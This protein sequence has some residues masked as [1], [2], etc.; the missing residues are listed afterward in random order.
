MEGPDQT[1]GFQAN[2][3]ACDGWRGLYYMLSTLPLDDP[4]FRRADE[5]VDRLRATGW[6]T[7][8]LAIER[9]WKR[10][11]WA[12]DQCCGRVLEIGAGM[13]NVTRWIA[14]NPEVREVVALDITEE[15]IRAL[16]EFGWPK[17]NP[18]CANIHSENEKI[19]K[20]G[21]FDA[22]VMAEFIEHITIDEEIAL[23]GVVRPLMAPGGVWIITTPIGFMKAQTHVRG[24]NSPLFRAR[25]RL[26]YGPIEA[27]GDNDIQQFAVCR[28]QALS[29]GRRSFR[30][31]LARVLETL[32]AT[33]PSGLPY[34]PVVIPC[35]SVTR[36][37]GRVFRK[38]RRV[39]GH[40]A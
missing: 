11:K 18:I 27:T 5:T 12:A 15:Y 26:L 3:A 24:F 6:D 32:F 20:L 25:C 29:Q 31:G 35:R 38:V 34:A 8:V 1:H 30:T 9:Y 14:R 17:V 33:R 39:R 19:A 13:G 16:R 22:V 10:V 23:L 7:S 36:F 21:P 28:D 40:G 37:V 4:E 2:Q